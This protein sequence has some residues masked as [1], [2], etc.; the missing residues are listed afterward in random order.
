MTNHITI[1]QIIF[2]ILLII[3]SLITLKHLGGYS[4]EIPS[5]VITWSLMIIFICVSLINVILKQKFFWSQNT[6]TF[7]F[8]FNNIN[9]FFN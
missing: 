5:N 2:Y 1:W 8:R 4:T 3:P 9:H 7:Y 6:V